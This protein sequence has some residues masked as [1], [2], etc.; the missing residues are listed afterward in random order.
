[1]KEAFHKNMHFAFTSFSFK[2]EK[3]NLLFA[4]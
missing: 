3:S 4:L 2:L 1:M